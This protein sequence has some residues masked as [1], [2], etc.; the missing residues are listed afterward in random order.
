MDNSEEINDESEK[1]M[2]LN[3]GYYMRSKRR[4]L[5]KNVEECTSFFRNTEKKRKNPIIYMPVEILQ[6]IFRFVPH[7]EL[8]QS[9]RLVN[10]RF[11]IVAEDVLN[12]SFR[13]LE[14]KIN[15]LILS[16]E[17]SLAFTQDDMEIKCIAKLL[18]MLEILK[19]QYS[20]VVSTIWR[21]VYNDF[22]KTNKTCMYAGQLI[23]AYFNFIDKFI[24]CPNILYAPAVIRDYA[25]P[26]EVAKIIQLTKSFCVHFDKISEEPRT[27]CLICSGCKI[28]DIVDCAKYSQKFVVSEVA[29]KNYFVAEY[30]YVFRNSWFVALPVKMTKEMEWSQK[31]RMMHMRLRRIVLAH[32]DMFLQQYQ[33]DREVMLRPDPIIGRIKKP[34]NNVYTGYGDIGDTFFYYGV[35]NDG[36]YAQK[37]N[38][39]E[40]NEEEEELDE[41]LALE[42]IG[43][44][45]APRNNSSENV[46]YRIPYLGF[47]MNVEVKCPLSYAP[48]NFLKNMNDIDLQ[49]LRN[50]HRTQGPTHIKV[51]FECEGASYPRLPTRFE[52]DFN[53]KKL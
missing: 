3:T 9:V 24:H 29:C 52:Y 27:D 37:F 14:K 1:E 15:N 33:Y 7:H 13:H 4:K 44:D 25:L 45:I 5:D 17:I 32:N 36:A 50:K 41:M 2:N 46:L 12:C 38:Q 30:S 49:K 34:G 42:D 28:I 47:K 51:M 39:D 11:K 18:N 26:L 35:M 23:D 43:E 22:Y 48:L 31:Q 40:D 8:S 20:I 19:L 6:A 21:Y 53:P 10:H 16:A